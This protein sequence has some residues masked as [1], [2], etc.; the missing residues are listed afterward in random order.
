MQKLHM[1]AMCWKQSKCSK[2]YKYPKYKEYIIAPPT[3]TA[4]KTNPVD[5]YFHPMAVRMAMKGEIE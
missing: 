3:S 5:Y 2:C 4:L 1:Y